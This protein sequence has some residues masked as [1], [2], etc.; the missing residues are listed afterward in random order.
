MRC[1]F[2]MKK[3]REARQCAARL[4][5]SSVMLRSV[6]S[7][8]DDPICPHHRFQLEHHTPS[9]SCSMKLLSCTSQ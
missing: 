4:L 2:E 8:T 5:P 7:E 3:K 1:S 6:L 9:F